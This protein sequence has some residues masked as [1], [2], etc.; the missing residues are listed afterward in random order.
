MTKH[1]ALNLRQAMF[2]AAGWSESLKADRAGVRVY[3]FKDCRNGTF[4]IER[5]A[6]KRFRKPGHK[7]VAT[8]LHGDV[9]SLYVPLHIERDIFPPDCPR[10]VTQDA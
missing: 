5:N 1:M 3:L 7:I 8:F 2:L 9:E 10:K 6:S 4:V